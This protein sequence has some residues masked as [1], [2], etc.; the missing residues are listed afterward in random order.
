M[1]E[2]MQSVK[3]HAKKEML[4]F[5]DYM[6]DRSID[7]AMS[8]SVSPDEAALNIRFGLLLKK[9]SENLKHNIFTEDD[10]RFVYK[11]IKKKEAKRMAWLEKSCLN[12]WQIDYENR[13]RRSRDWERSGMDE[14][15]QKFGLDSE[16]D[17]HRAFRETLSDGKPL[18]ENSFEDFLRD[19]KLS[20]RPELDMSGVGSGRDTRSKD[21]S[22]G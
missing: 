4:D 9:Y 18:K 2:M 19:G 6:G 8:M 16:I 14:T 21:R 13:E 11:E 10:C 22:R 1:G 7:C 12:D 17:A 20:E 3:Y 15:R 5:L